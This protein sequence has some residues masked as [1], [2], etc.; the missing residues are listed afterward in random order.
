MILVYDVKVERVNKICNY[1]KRYL[2]WV[3]NSVF[4]GELTIGELKKIEEDMK[5]LI[6]ID[7]DSVRIYVYPSEKSIRKK[8]IGKRYREPTQI[9]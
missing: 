2:N 9:I 7:E 8:H 3:Q 5:N 4:E 1:L 6:S